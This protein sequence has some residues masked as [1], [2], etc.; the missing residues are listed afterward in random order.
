[1]D[2]GYDGSKYY[3]LNGTS[4]FQSING[5]TVELDIYELKKEIAN[6]KFVDLVD[7]MGVMTR[8]FANDFNSERRMGFERMYDVSMSIRKVNRG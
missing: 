4:Q 1:V 8:V 3:V 5:N 7:D 6:N 2:V